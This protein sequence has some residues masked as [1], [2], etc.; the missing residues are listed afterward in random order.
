MFLKLTY[1]GGDLDKPIYVRA[2]QIVW[3][4]LR[5]WGNGQAATHVLT[6]AGEFHC[7]ETPEQIRNLIDHAEM[8]Y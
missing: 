2:D 1:T 6:S 4:M 3:F 5:K 7:D 8:G